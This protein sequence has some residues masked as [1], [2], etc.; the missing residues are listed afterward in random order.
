MIDFDAKLNGLK[1]LKWCIPTYG[2][3]HCMSGGKFFLYGGEPGLIFIILLH[4]IDKG[5]LLSATYL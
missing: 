1:H 2:V 5:F 3:V 4:P